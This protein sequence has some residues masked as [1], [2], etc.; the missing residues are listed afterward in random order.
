MAKNFPN[1]EIFIAVSSA[2]QYFVR[3]LYDVRNGYER[4]PQSMESMSDRNSVDDSKKSV[5]T[6]LRGKVARLLGEYDLEE[7]GD[8]LVEYYTRETD[9]YSLRDLTSL[10]N[11]R[12]TEAF[13]RATGMRLTQN[14]ADQIYQSLTADDVSSGDRTRVRRRLERAG[15][16]IDQLETSFVSYEAIR[17]Y[18]RQRGATHPESDTDQVD[19]EAQHLQQLKS[20]TTKVTE[21]KLEN[22]RSTDRISLGDFRVLTEI[23]VYCE[24]CESQFSVKSLLERRGC[25]CRSPAAAD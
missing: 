5:S 2:T 21:G 12:L 7:V 1:S 6:T 23:E 16:D 20:R 4:P 25:N 14:E 11:R 13:A 8:N 15:V 17:T 24:A 18:L 3:M 10:F 19:K 9:R 22:L